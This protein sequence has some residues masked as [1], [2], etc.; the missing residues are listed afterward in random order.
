MRHCGEIFSSYTGNST[1][2]S[3]NTAKLARDLKY[4]TLGLAKANLKNANLEHIAKETSAA[5]KKLEN[6][7]ALLRKSQE[8]S[9][10]KANDLSKQLQAMEAML[11]KG[12]VSP[13]GNN[14]NHHGTS[15][16]TEDREKAAPSKSENL[17]TYIHEENAGPRGV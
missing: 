15:T 2:H 10:R 9:E 14:A 13:V 16:V 6:E 4:N 11:S 12:L 8:E 17:G 7:T 1:V 5:K 3:A